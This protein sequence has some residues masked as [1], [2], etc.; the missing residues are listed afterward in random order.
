MDSTPFY[1]SYAALWVLIILHSLV[2]LG[3]VRIVY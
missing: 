2:L 3:V 1:L